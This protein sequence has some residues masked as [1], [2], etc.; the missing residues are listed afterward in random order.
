[1]LCWVSLQ[2]PAT[3]TRILLSHFHWDKEKL[4]E[5]QVC[6]S[7]LPFLSKLFLKKYLFLDQLDDVVKH[8]FVVHVRFK[9]STHASTRL[10]TSASVNARWGSTPKLKHCYKA[11]FFFF[12][13]T[14]VF[15]SV[16][17]PLRYFDGNL[18]KLFSECHVINP[19]KKARTRPMSTR[20]SNQDMHCQICYLNYPTSVSNIAVTLVT[21]TRRVRAIRYPVRADIWNT[22]YN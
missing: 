10:T 11:M 19:S 3:I 5:R 1:M 2:N 8:G 20:S 4:M 21:V 14:F 9:H 12:F 13:I 7:F 16:F 15:S 6:A 17:S 22:G 18:D